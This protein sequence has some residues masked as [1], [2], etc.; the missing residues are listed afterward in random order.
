MEKK[1]ASGTYYLATDNA[2]KQD[3]PYSLRSKTTDFRSITV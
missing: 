3:T 1:G 2:E